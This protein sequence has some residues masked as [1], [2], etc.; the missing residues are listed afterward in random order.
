MLHQIHA[1]NGLSLH[2]S[3]KAGS[4]FATWRLG[5]L[6]FWRLFLSL[7]HAATFVHTAYTSGL[8]AVTPVLGRGVF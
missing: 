8:R 4:H 7:V 6:V 1:A 2:L 3:L 5:G